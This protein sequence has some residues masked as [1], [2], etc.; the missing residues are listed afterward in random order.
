MKSVSKTSRTLKSLAVAGTLAFAVAGAFAQ[1]P[2]AKW[3]LTEHQ[4]GIPG[5]TKH[6]MAQADFSGKP[7]A[8]AEFIA[9]RQAILNHMTA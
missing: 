6:E 8:N 5:P 9:D 3:E 1:T 7:N 2:A 4:K